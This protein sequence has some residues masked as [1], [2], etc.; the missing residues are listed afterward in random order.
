MC[1]NRE[2]CKF[3]HF[4]MRQN[5]TFSDDDSDLT[6][7]NHNHLIYF[8]ENPN[9]SRITLVESDIKRSKSAFSLVD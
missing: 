9:G 7:N 8:M 1:F 2:K 3:M 6:T 5:N 4:S